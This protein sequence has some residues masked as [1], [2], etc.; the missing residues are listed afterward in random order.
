[1]PERSA[2]PPRAER[3][4]SRPRAASCRR[5]RLGAIVENHTLA[6]GRVLLRGALVSLGSAHQA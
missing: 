5:G 4:E 2:A 6:S 1:M 3:F